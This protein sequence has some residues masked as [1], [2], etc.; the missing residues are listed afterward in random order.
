LE[1]YREKEELVPKCR[2]QDGYLYVDSPFIKLEKQLLCSDPL[3]PETI[4][5][6]KIL[7]MA[8]RNNHPVTVH[9]PYGEYVYCTDGA[10]LDINDGLEQDF[11]SSVSIKLPNEAFIPILEQLIS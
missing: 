10:W 3:R 5:A 8:M 1:L 11:G 9:D 6:F 2:I 4:Q 7:L